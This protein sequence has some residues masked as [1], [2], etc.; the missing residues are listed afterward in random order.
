MWMGDIDRRIDADRVW[1]RRITEYWSN[2]KG[3]NVRFCLSSL[4]S[5]RGQSQLSV[6]RLSG[7]TPALL[8]WPAQADGTCACR[9]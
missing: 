5:R 7:K 4:G 8:R 2:S 9:R 3:M 6:G 1:P